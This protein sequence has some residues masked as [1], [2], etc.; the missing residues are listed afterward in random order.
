[1]GPPLTERLLPTKH[2]QPWAP[3]SYA[4]QKEGL[5]HLTMY[6]MSLYMWLPRLAAIS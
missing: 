1:M 6:W 2:I 3:G 5:Y 4:R